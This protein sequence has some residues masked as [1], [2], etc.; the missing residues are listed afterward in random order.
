MYKDNKIDIYSKNM[1]NLKELNKEYIA[2]KNS[3]EYKLGRQLELLKNNLSIKR[4]D[5]LV[6]LLKKKKILLKASKVQKRIIEKR[7]NCIDTA[8]KNESN[9]Y[10]DDRI[11]I[12]TCVVGAY[13]SLIEP[14]TVPD[15]CDFYFFTDTEKNV[16]SSVW[17][18][19][20]IDKNRYHL[21]NM[22]NSEI[23]RFFKMH[24]DKVFPNYKYSI[25]VDGNIK[26]VT[27]LTEYINKIKAYGLAL[28]RH[29]SRNCVYDEAKV[30]EALGKDRKENME[31]HIKVLREMGFPENFGM[32][33]CNIIARE[34]NNDTCKQIMNLWW[35]DFMTL[36]KRDQMSLPS[37]LYRLNIDLNDVATLGYGVDNDYAVRVEGH[38]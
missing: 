35:E 29:S 26:I 20:L 12:Y 25:Y 30:I 24:P 11:A 21:E 4:I 15:N 7:S 32:L 9:Y 5:E 33:E 22:S 6:K 38:K 36:S 8:N 3:P 10:S 23:N 1:E 18:S 37:V 16:K 14:I 34:H 31:R 17:K 19:V 2:L 28:H 27:D 13:D